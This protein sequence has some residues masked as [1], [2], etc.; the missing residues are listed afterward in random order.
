[1]AREA[2]ILRS[3]LIRLNGR[4]WLFGCKTLRLEVVVNKGKIK[5]EVRNWA[6]KKE[7][8]HRLT[9]INTDKKN[10]GGRN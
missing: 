8:S 4:A 10:E 1:L 9:P 3:E 2:R 6:K 7:F 5:L